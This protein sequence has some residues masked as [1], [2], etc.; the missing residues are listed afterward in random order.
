MRVAVATSAD[1][2]AL[3]RDG[4]LLL[5]A[6]A[7]AGAIVDVT[8]WDDPEVDWRAHDL[9]LLRSTW[10]YHL[11]RDEFLAWAQRCRATSNPIG[12]IRWNSDKRY[13]VDLRDAGVPIVPTVF[14]EPGQR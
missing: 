11:R 6:L 9:V 7:D 5:T 8:V 14:A 3:D 10:D 13:L 2:P 4:P 1:V 12:V